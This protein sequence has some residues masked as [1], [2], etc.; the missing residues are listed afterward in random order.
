MHLQIF[1]S[2]FLKVVSLY[3][4]R[5]SCTFN[6]EVGSVASRT[7]NLG[8]ICMLSFVTD[9]LCSRQ[10]PNTKETI[11][12]LIA[13]KSLVLNITNNL[14]SCKKNKNKRCVFHLASLN[15]LLNIHHYKKEWD[16]YEGKPVQQVLCQILTRVLK[17]LLIQEI[18][19]LQPAF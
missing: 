1:Y 6:S 13:S 16:C 7:G 17:V 4:P 10:K 19:L 5:L 15:N 11:L 18:P 3:L 9:V 8:I 2:Y 12:Q 14:W